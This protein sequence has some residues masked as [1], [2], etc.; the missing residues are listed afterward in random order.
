MLP[1]LA[2]ITHPL[3]SRHEMGHGHPECPARLDAIHDHLVGQG[4]M[5]YVHAETARPATDE[6]LLRAHSL[7]HLDNLVFHA[8]AQGYSSIDAD[9][10]M[11]SFTLDAARYAAGA[12]VQATDLVLTGKAQRAFCAVRPPGH[13]AERNRAMGFCFYSNIAIAAL[14]SIAV[15]GIER[16]AIVDFDVHHGNGTENI[17]ADN[18]NILMVST[19]QKQLYPFSGEVPLGK[20]MCNVGLPPRT[21]GDV[22]REAV[23]TQL[24]P[25]LDAFK[26]E[27]IF[28]SAGFDAHLE[29]DMANL[30]WSDADYAWITARIVEVADRHA[31]GRIVS[32]LEGGYALPALGR[33][34]AAHVGVLLGINDA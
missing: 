20:N 26:P 24:L 33:S 11:N 1:H 13:H 12:A 4:L 22:M 29:D 7:Q 25:A 21:R 2:Y 28:I 15:Y 27:V 18:P 32:S 3:F 6:E 34:V 17:V 14:H 10:V 16:A 8:P 23:T 31:Q 19:F 9:T 30:G 5:D